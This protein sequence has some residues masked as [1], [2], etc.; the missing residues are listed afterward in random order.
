MLDALKQGALI[1][2]IESKK[3]GKRQIQSKM[4]FEM[5]KIDRERALTTMNLWARFFEFGF[6]R[7]HHTKFTSLDEYIPYR[8]AD[9]GEM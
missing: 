9:L 7:R 8:I 6:G 1:G 2:S 3:S 4:L 5:L